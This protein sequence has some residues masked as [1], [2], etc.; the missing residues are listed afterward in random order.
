MYLEIW[1]YSKQKLVKLGQNLQHQNIINTGYFIKKRPNYFILCRK[2]IYKLF[3][4]DCPVQ[5]SQ[6]KHNDFRISSLEGLEPKVG[7]RYVY[8]F[9]NDIF[10]FIVWKSKSVFLYFFSTYK[11]KGVILKMTRDSPTFGSS[12]S[13]ND[14]ILHQ[15]Y[16]KV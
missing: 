5:S 8:H 13:N 1:V 2:C 9:H 10:N 7:V 14:E 4:L 6:K 11:I 16:E 12:P 3:S 15:C